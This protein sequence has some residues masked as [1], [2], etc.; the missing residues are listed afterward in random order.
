MIHTWWSVVVLN[1]SNLYSKFGG[2]HDHHIICFSMLVFLE[3]QGIPI[4]PVQSNY[5][6]SLWPYWS[7]PI[8]CWWPWSL[9]VLTLATHLLCWFWWLLVI[10]YEPR[11][12]ND[13]GI[14]P[15]NKKHVFMIFKGVLAIEQAEWWCPPLTL[16]CIA[17]S[18]YIMTIMCVSYTIIITYV[19][20]PI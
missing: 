16:Y 20:S 19:C 6:H 15:L 8:G 14:D 2:Q 5:D 11:L 12:V 17:P 3:P 9:L 1:D 7:I 13:Y 10:T 18:M 4:R